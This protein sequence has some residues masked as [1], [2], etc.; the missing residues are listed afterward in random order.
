MSFISL[1]RVSLA[2][3][4][5]RRSTQDTDRGVVSECFLNHPHPMS[6]SHILYSR[7]LANFLWEVVSTLCATVQSRSLRVEFVKQP[8]GRSCCCRYCSFRAVFC[9]QR[10]S[11]ALSMLLVLT[12]ILHLCDVMFAAY[13]SRGCDRKS[14]PIH[15]ALS[16][17][18]NRQESPLGHEGQISAKSQHFLEPILARVYS[19]KQ[20]DRNENEK[21]GGAESLARRIRH[22]HSFLE[23]LIQGVSL[24]H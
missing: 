10:P 20:S 4:R 2:V 17:C 1:I 22:P 15:A 12:L 23:V 18:C 7:Y 21:Q 11:I 14:C 8:V 3:A 19:Y 9:A 16:C 5:A 6:A 24:L 13:S